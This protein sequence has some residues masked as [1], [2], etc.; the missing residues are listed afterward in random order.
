MNRIEMHDFSTQYIGMLQY[1]LFLH[2]SIHNTFFDIGIFAIAAFT[3][4]FCINEERAF[5]SKEIMLVIIQASIADTLWCTQ[6]PCI[7]T[8]TISLLTVCLTAITTAF[9]CFLLSTVWIRLILEFLTNLDKI[10]F[11]VKTH[12]LFLSRS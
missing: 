4:S 8:F 10:F 5:I 9:F 3:F 7:K 12:L 11:L 2:W 6:L 1:I